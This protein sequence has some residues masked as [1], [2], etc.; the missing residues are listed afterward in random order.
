[1]K[2]KKYLKE[3]TINTNRLNK[4]V[5]I[6]GSIPSDSPESI[7]KY[8]VD[9]IKESGIKIPKGN[10]TYLSGPMTNLP[11]ENWPAFIYAEKYLKGKIINP[12]KPH[13]KIVKKPVKS[14]SWNDYMTED[15]YGMIEG[16]KIVVLP[17]YTKSTGAIVEVLIG[18]KLLNTKPKT[19]KSVIGEKNYLLWVQ[20]V[21]EQYIKDNNE[22]EYNSVIEPMLIS[23]SERDSAAFVKAW[24]PDKNESIDEG[25]KD[26][27]AKIKN[28]IKS[29]SLKSVFNLIGLLLK[30]GGIK[31]P[32]R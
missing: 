13:G 14:F 25:L 5:K 21:K 20:D 17:G 12:A 19:L 22:K 4:L 30:N 31:V 6:F 1:M 15:I 11:N 16:N 27:A 18:E 10:A 28:V 7:A 2:F 23:K 32:V 8:V 29:G 24:M 26:I 3:F 9:A